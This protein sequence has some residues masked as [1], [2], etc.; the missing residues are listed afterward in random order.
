MKNPAFIFAGILA[1]TALSAT[2]D[3]LMKNRKIAVT[4]FSSLPDRCFRPKSCFM[5]KQSENYKDIHQGTVLVN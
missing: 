1:T 2:S 3:L 4:P 5:I